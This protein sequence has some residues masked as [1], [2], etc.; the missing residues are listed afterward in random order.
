MRAEAKGHPEDAR[1]LFNR[2]WQ[3]RQNALDACIAAHFVARQQESFEEMLY[4]NKQALN[5]A[6]AVGDDR[7]QGFYPSFYLNLGRS[8]EFL[9][10]QVEAGHF[11][12]L[13][14]ETSDVLPDGAYTEVVRNGIAA[15]RG[16]TS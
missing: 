4:W 7:V 13:A 9:G 5:Y 14:A 16:R 15:G 3:A 10:N 2:A 12:R 1:Q 8:H 11:Y 6:D